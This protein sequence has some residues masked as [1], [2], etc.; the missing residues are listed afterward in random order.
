MDLEDLHAR[1][2]LRGLGLEAYADAF[3]QEGYSS[4]AD[5]LDASDNDLFPLFARM[6]P[7]EIKTFCEEIHKLRRQND[8][9]G[10][11][12]VLAGSG[13]ANDE[14]KLKDLFTDLGLSAYAEALYTEGYRFVS[15]LLDES[16][17]ELG[18]LL[19]Q[20]EPPHKELVVAALNAR[21]GQDGAGIMPVL[22]DRDHVAVVRDEMDVGSVS[23]RRL[24]PSQCS[25]NTFSCL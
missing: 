3:K 16:E 10:V 25:R 4:V 24:L 12:A 1:G 2:F 6:A 13:A 21:R 7:S 17:D 9:N 19:D 20:M 5:L 18:K 22:F 23:P 8:S 14:Q 11:P 15:D